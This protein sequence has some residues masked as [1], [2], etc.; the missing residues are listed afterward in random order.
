MWLRTDARRFH[1]DLVLVLELLQAVD[2]PSA[3][4]CVED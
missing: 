2:I 3:E 1:Q 4:G